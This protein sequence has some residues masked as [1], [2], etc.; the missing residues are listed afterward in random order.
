MNTFGERLRFFRQRKALTQEQLAQQIG[1]AKTTITGYEKNNREPDVI[2][3]KKIA[4]ALEVTGDELLGIS[5]NKESERVFSFN[6]QKHIR[7]YRTLDDH[8][9][10]LVNMATD[11]EYERC[12][13]D[14]PKASIEEEAADYEIPLL[15][16]TAA[17]TPLSYG[18]PSY[19]YIK[20]KRIPPGAK[21]ALM[22][23]GQSME[24]DIMDNSIVFI[25]P[26]PVAENSEIVVVEID[27]EVTCKKY[28]NQGGKVSFEPIN[29]EF[30]PIT[31]FEECRIIG[32]VI[33][34]KS[35]GINKNNRMQARGLK[36]VYYSFIIY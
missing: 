18:A 4:A 2:K 7:K 10:G 24:P 26:Q 32:K 30:K 35:E 1:V 25:R 21:F 16:K 20:V 28:R 5:I 11:K 12:L 33:F 34:W 31:V 29:P 19:E 9:R 14:N 17:G 3:I 22:V 27:G 13:A 36:Y 8:G 6:E 15:G 23:D